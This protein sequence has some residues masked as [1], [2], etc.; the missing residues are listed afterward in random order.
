[1][2]IRRIETTD[3][4]SVHH[5]HNSLHL[6]S[7]RTRYVDGKFLKIQFSSLLPVLFC[8]S[9]LTASAQ[10]QSLGD[11]SFVVPAG[12][13]YSQQPG[14]NVAT[15]SRS[16]GRDYCIVL[17]TEPFQMTHNVNTDFAITWKEIVTSSL[18]DPL[19]GGSLL[20]H[21]SSSGYSGKLNGGPSP[22]RGQSRWVSLFLLEAGTKVIPV[23]VAS[24]NEINLH[25][26]PPVVK[27]LDSIRLG[28]RASFAGNNQVEPQT[29]VGQQGTQA[30]Y[31]QQALE[32]Q[33]SPELQGEQWH[34]N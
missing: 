9:P 13:I 3:R 4:R 25:L 28:S 1:M 15:V 33:K 10:M 24:S 6:W 27:F 22:A 23:V 29:E 12:W 32:E 11:L 14:F 34:E 19:P 26:Y 20:E 21:S 5:K 2:K 30:Y 16:D 17:I 18:R 7:S 8:L 31:Q